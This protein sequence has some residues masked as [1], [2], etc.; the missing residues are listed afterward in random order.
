MTVRMSRFLPLDTWLLIDEQAIE[1]STTE[2]LQHYRPTFE[3][4]PCV[5]C[6]FPVGAGHSMACPT[7]AY[8]WR[9]HNPTSMI[10]IVGT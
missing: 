7:Y 8:S 10:R 1:A 4:R 5:R 2:A 3:P 6:H 9:V